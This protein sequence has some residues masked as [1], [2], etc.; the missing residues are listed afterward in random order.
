MEFKTQLRKI[1]KNR[2]II[3]KRKKTLNEKI[4]IIIKTLI[5][6]IKIIIKTLI[7]KIKIIIKTL[8]EKK[9]NYKNIK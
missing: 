7:E 6:K 8:N 4:K 1:R 3:E 9:N 5:E 2:E